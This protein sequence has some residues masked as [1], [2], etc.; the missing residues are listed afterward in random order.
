MA[1]RMMKASSTM[2]GLIGSV[3]K[4]DVERAKSIGSH[5]IDQLTRARHRGAFELAAEAFRSLCI[6][7]RK[8]EATKHLLDQW[9]QECLSIITDK[10]KID[11]L[12]QTRRSAGLPHLFAALA[13]ADAA[14]TRE[15][16]VLRDLVSVGLIQLVVLIHV[17]LILCNSSKLVFS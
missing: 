5:L 10:T 6:Q 15:K 11:A 1:W 17:R 14:T 16:A 9:C 8:Q 13:C 3:F 2:L 12:C 7:T 4:L